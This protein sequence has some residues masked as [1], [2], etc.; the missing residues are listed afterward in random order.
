MSC[1][2]CRDMVRYGGSGRMKQACMDRNCKNMTVKFKEDKNQ[3]LI[4]SMFSQVRVKEEM[5]VK[6]G[7]ELRDNKRWCQEEYIRRKDV[8]NK[9]IFCKNEEGENDKPSTSSRVRQEVVV[10]SEGV[11]CEILGAEYVEYVEVKLELSES[12]NKQEYYNDIK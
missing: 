4:T 12:A 1:R 11:K 6:E 8:D 2:H 7:K 3:P 10:K 9:G 5:C